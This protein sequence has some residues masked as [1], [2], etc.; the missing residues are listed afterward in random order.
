MM[1]ADESTKCPGPHFKKSDQPFVNMTR[2]WF[3]TYLCCAGKWL[4]LIRRIT[5]VIYMQLYTNIHECD[6]VGYLIWLRSEPCIHKSFR[7]GS[8]IVIVAR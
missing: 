2:L 6:G 7:E 8:C 1:F 3:R 4:T 5:K